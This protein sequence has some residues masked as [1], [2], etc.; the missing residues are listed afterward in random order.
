MSVEKI[1]AEADSGERSDGQTPSPSNRWDSRRKLSTLCI[2][3]IASFVQPSVATTD[4]TSSR[5][6]RA[7]SGLAARGYRAWVKL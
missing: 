5:R 3:P 1:S 6:I 4:S 7:Y 2:L